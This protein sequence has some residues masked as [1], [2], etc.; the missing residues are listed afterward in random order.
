MLKLFPN[1]KYIICAPPK[2]EKAPNGCSKYHLI[3]YFSESAIYAHVK[4]KTQTGSECISKSQQPKKACI[5]KI[6]YGKAWVRVCMSCL[7]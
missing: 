2:P 1:R 7:G 5:G 4:Q 3:Y 6:R